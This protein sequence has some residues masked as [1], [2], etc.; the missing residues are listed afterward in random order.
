VKRD[1]A[2]EAP[3]RRLWVAAT[4]YVWSWAGWLY[5]SFVLAAHSRRTVGWSMANNLKTGLVPDAVNVAIYNRRP[6]PGLIHHSDG[7]SQYTF[8]VEFGS[9]L[10]GAALLLPPMRDRWPTPTTTTTR[11]P[12][13]SSRP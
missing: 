3:D 9:R 4:T 1:V 10:K 11:W 12:R 7:G 2:P 6:A 5:L 13:A 8:A